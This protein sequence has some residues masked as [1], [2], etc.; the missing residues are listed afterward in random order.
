MRRVRKRSNRPLLQTPDPEATMRRLMD[1]R[2][3]TY[4]LADL[5]VYSQDGPQEAMVEA[6]ISAIARQLAPLAAPPLV[7]PAGGAPQPDGSVTVRVDLGQR[8]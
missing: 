5:T 6:V 1:E 4:A 8:S 2:H 3:P 7:V